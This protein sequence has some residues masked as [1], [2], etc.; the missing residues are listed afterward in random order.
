[1]AVPD[2][3][4]VIG[5]AGGVGS[6]KSTV[7]RAFE[8]LGCL[9][10]DSDRLAR[11]ALTNKDVIAELRGW[12]GDRV[13]DHE[14]RIDRRAVAGIVFHDSVQRDRL[15]ALIHPMIRASRQELIDRAEHANA[16]AVIVDAPLL[17]EAGLDADCDAIVFVDAPRSVRLER[18]QRNRNWDERELDRREAS[19]MGLDEKRRRSSHVVQNGEIDREALSE[20][21]RGIL[22][23]L[24][25]RRP[26]RA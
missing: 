12:W 22:E 21:V 9:V 24:R 2:R 10:S 20:Q 19:Q 4:I 16:P 15:E 13:L 23:E 11:N 17:F 6:G 8:E 18:V 14:G 25:A 26:E 5:L 7:A 3:P 1:M